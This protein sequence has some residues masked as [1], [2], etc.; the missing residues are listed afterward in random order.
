[1]VRLAPR[2][3]PRLLDALAALDDRAVPMA[4]VCRRLGRAADDLG[5]VRPSYVHIRR[6]L[7]A[8]REWQDEEAKKRAELRALAID[9]A[10][11]Y[12]AGG[13]VNWHDVL[14]RAAEI[15]DR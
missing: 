1:M 9:V 12:A 10:T 13:W 14:A 15:R 4:E 8:L 7:V 2:Y 5:L 3:D 11:A 6:L